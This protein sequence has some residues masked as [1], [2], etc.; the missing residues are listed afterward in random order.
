MKRKWLVGIIAYAVLLAACLL[1][2]YAIPSIKGLMVKTYI[3][4]Q[5]EIVVSDEVDAYLIRD[6]HVY[7]AKNGA[8]VNRLAEESKLIRAGIKVVELEGEGISSSDKTYSV[9]LSNLGKKKEKT[10]SGVSNYA[11][12]ISYKV[13]GAESQL[14]PKAMKKI[15]KAKLDE[16]S[17]Q[18]L[19]N[20]AKGKCAPGDPIFKVAKNGKYYLIFY[21]DNKSA[22]RYEL[23]DDVVITV[24]DKE[25][26][27]TVHF[28]KKGKSYSKIILKCGIQYD[29]CLTDRKIKTT[30]TTS[31]AKGLVIKDSSIVKRKKQKGVIVKNRL[32]DYIFT[33]VCIKA[34]DGERCVVYQDLYMDD[35]GQYVETIS[36]YDEVLE[37]PSEEDLKKAE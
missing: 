11:G 32:G 24:G 36:I 6:E 22:K 31:S 13:D 25:I 34:D 28:I 10:A 1:I 18:D 33:P 21:L 23:D 8:K 16:L 26:D 20:T 27:S 29:G 35:S 37:S 3:A 4:E 15:T 17:S 19:K 5:G 7:V 14:T 12:Y 30:V 9:I 2:V